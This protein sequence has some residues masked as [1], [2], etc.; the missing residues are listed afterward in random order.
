MI[1]ENIRTI[2]FDAGFTL[3]RISPSLGEVYARVAAQLGAPF[4]AERFQ[5]VGIRVWNRER[6]PLH[7]PSLESSDAIERRFWWDYN[8]IIVRE[9][10]R[11]GLRVDFEPWFETLFE[12]FGQPETWAPLDGAA[13][14]LGELN[15]RGYRLGVVSNWDSRLQRVLDGLDLT[16]HFRMVLTSAQA[17]YRKPSPRIFAQALGR[18]DASAAESL[19]VGDSEEDDVGG[20]LA[21]GLQAIRLKPGRRLAGRAVTS[22]ASHVIGA[23]PELLDLLGAPGSRTR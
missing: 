10:E 2:L 14:T 3:I 7:A 1:I 6:S 8:R 18:M 13:R 21:A 20:A 9:L 23:L 22:A 16:R 4:S 5:E 15:R 19:H 11:E 12:I 17:G